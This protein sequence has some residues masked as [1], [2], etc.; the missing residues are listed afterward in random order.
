MGPRQIGNFHETFRTIQVTIGKISIFYLQTKFFKLFTWEVRQLGE[1][2]LSL[3]LSTG[4]KRPQTCG[5]PP[6]KVSPSR[7]ALDSLPLVSSDTLTPLVS[8][9]AQK[10]DCRITQITQKCRDKNLIS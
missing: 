10:P 6:I 5:V 2:R 1:T 3:S 9:L 7:R 8:G 4:A